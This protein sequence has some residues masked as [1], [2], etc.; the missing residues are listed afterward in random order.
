MLFVG[1]VGF[2]EFVELSVK[3]ILVTAI[4]RTVVTIAQ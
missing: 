2:V 4:R 3:C 1:F